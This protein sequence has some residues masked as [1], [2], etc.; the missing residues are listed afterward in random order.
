MNKLY[1]KSEQGFSLLEMLLVVVL[2]IGSYII[3]FELLLKYKEQR[4]AKATGEYIL[5]VANAIEDI[6]SNPIY[7]N[8][9]YNETNSQTNN[10]LDLSLDD[11]K[12][13]GFTSGTIVNIP[14][15]ETITNDFLNQTPYRTG[16]FIMIR[17]ADNVLDLNDIPALEIII[18]LDNAIDY[19]RASYVTDTLLNT[20]GLFHNLKSDIYSVYSSWKMNPNILV[21]TSWSIKNSSSPLNDDQAYV[22]YYKHISQDIIEGDY[23]YRIHVSGMPELNTLYGDL[24]LGGNNI[25]G[26]DNINTET[27]TVNEKAISNE[28]V[29]VDGNTLMRDSNIFAGNIVSTDNV[30][31]NGKSGTG[32]ETATFINSGEVRTRNLRVRNRLNSDSATFGSNVNVINNASINSATTG[33]RNIVSNRLRSNNA[34]IQGNTQLND[35]LNTQ[36]LSASDISVNNGSVGAINGTIQQRDYRVNG[37]LNTRDLT[38]ERLNVSTFGECD[39]GC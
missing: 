33:I 36:N 16:V 5:T 8:E 18:S 34:E 30:I 38:I 13:G 19:K 20:G 15:S 32:G 21:G 14:E 6:I 2:V 35:Q 31:I 11:L 25:L 12:S 22:F 17:V 4:V 1:T 7:F 23:L 29:D 3:I 26:A 24:E 39:Y 10:I 37:T 9:I 27:I 28:S